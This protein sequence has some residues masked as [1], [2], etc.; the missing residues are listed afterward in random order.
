MGV[1]RCGSVYFFIVGIFHHFQEIGIQVRLALEIKDEV[2]KLF[3]NFI[4]G[5]FEEIILQHAGR[6]GKLPQAA[7]AFG[8]TQVATGG[9]LKGNGNRITPLNR[10]VKQPACIKTAEHFNAV[11]KTTEGKLA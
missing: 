8:A 5:S 10:F 9:W 11:Y 4:N 3:M 7:G 1:G 2:K 6:T